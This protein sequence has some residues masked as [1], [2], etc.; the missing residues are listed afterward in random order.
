M[1]VAIHVTVAVVCG[2]PLP[3]LAQSSD[4]AVISRTRGVHVPAGAITGDAD[5]TAVELNPGAVGLVRLP[6]LRFVYAD[7]GVDTGIRAGSGG[8]VFVVAPLPGSSLGLGLQYLDPPHALE[9]D[10]DPANRSVDLTKLSIAFAL[11]LG[12]NLGLGLTWHHFFADRAPALDGLDTFDVG[13]SLRPSRYAALGLVVHDLGQP[14]ISPRSRDCA[15]CPVSQER[16]YEPE[17]AIRPLGDHRLEIAG[18]ARIG[19]R[20]DPFLVDPRARLLLRLVPGV[21]LR[22]DFELVRRRWGEVDAAGRRPGFTSD[23]RVS[24]GLDVDLEH[25]GAGFAALFGSKPPAGAGGS[26]FHG[27]AV[28]GR[29]SA[30]RY[31]SIT[32]ISYVAKI[33]LD[34]LG[35]GARWT[36][37]LARLRELERS[38]EVEGVLFDLKDVRVGWGRL[39]ELRGAIESLKKS[40]RKTIFYF[41]QAALGGYYLA[42]AC[43]HIIAHPTSTLRLLGLSSTITFFKGAFDKLGVTPDFIKIAEYKSAPEQFTRESLSGPAREQRDA[44]L[45]HI[46]TTVLQRTADGRRMTVGD[47]KG[48]VAQGVYVAQEAKLKGLIDDVRY[49]DELE[50]AIGKLLGRGIGVHPPTGVPK[51]PEAW[52][53]PRVV[54]VH[55]DGDI[56][57]AEEE[58]G[59]FSARAAVGDVIAGAIKAAREDP[60]VRAIVLR[61]N[62]PGGSVLASD[63][64][65]REVELTRGKKPILASMGDVAASGGYYVSAPADRIF[66]EDLTVTGSIGIF[67]GKFDVSGL[68]RRVGVS[69]ETSTRGEHADAESIYRTYTDEE[70]ALLLAKLRKLYDAFLE[71]V[72]RNRKMSTTDV[73]KVG[74]G[75][76]WIGA[77]AREQGLVDEIGSLTDV[78]AEAKRRGGLLPDEDVDLEQVPRRRTLLARVVRELLGAEAQPPLAAF[79]RVPAL[80]ALLESLPPSLLLGGE[81]VYARLPFDLKLPDVR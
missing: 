11:R 10:Q 54:V 2:L 67:S 36:E 3:A 6:E 74:R 41:E 9:F 7:T 51:K 4:P 64:I 32:K 52:K 28:T 65:A 12:K 76:V 34:N 44:L 26:E 35:G 14:V 62:S 31:P 40:G 16:I 42:S 66:A 25:L 21:A 49:P 46:Y 27:F 80:R 1:R 5:A 39:T 22:G 17:L 20:T 60:G 23:V 75:R 55:V 24:A 38:P 18:G 48:H 57:D 30:E 58:S 70:R 77:A 68:L 63:K 33:E 53:R 78:I 43:D 61:V 37:L 59:L 29:L 69:W 45:D 71:I 47:L 19:E 73:D 8:G 79:A 13:L 72:A 50:D 56:V 15:T 81:G